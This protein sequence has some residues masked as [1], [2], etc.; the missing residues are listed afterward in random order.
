MTL[1]IAILMDPLEKLNVKSDSTLV[2]AAEARRRGY[3]VHCFGPGDLILKNAQV[4]ANLSE[5]H[6]TSGETLKFSAINPKFTLLETMD[7]I[8]IRQDPPFDMT[9][10]TTTYLLELI[11]DKVLIINNPTEIRNCPEKLFLNKFP[12]LLPP[13]IITRDKNQIEEFLSEHK[14]I[15]LKPLYAFGGRDVFYVKLG[16]ENFNPIF[17]ILREKYNDLII[18][19]KYLT[20]VKEGDKRI[21]LVN[22]KPI[23][24]LLRIPG[25]NQIR[26]NLAV[27]GKAE[28]TTLTRREQEI[29]KTIG[30]ELKKK[31]LILVGIDVIGDYLTEINVTSPTGIVAINQLENSK[32]ESVIWDEIENILS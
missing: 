20:E 29:C 3:N 5:L 31:G 27:G 6:I 2:L 26:A 23:G 13:T 15:V 14:Q 30:P 19:Q 11:S 25:K 18:A 4:F 8:F 24:A 1:S 9:Y 21:I 17:E 7:I 10:L 28:K 16:D 12:K 32:I 22:G